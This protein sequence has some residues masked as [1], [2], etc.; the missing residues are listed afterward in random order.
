M[1]FTPL[2]KRII[3]QV[4]VKVQNT[5]GLYIPEAA[6]QAPTA[7][8]VQSVGSQVTDVKAGDYIV[9]E[10]ATAKTVFLEGNEYLIINEE[11]ILAK[12]EK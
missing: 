1:K 7:A 11:D 5:E 9:Y 2:N 6:Q 4:V 12:V 8:E 10:P 3:A